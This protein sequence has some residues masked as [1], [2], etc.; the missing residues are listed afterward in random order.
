MTLELSVDSAVVDSEV[1]ER[2]AV[3]PDTVVDVADVVGI[4]VEA[5]AVLDLEVSSAV[6]KA[7]S[8]LKVVL[9]FRFSETFSE[10]TVVED[11]FWKFVRLIWIV[12]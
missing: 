6:V 8:G 12:C 1:G 11:M 4:I 7:V 9:M 2:P 10:S 3:V 5:A